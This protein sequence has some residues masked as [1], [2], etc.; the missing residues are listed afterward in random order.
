MEC[1]QMFP[2]KGGFPRAGSGIFTLP[3]G[4]GRETGLQGG[5]T[6]ILNAG[7]RNEH[8]WASSGILIMED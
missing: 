6:G 4:Y 3:E 8:I 5:A 2:V 7:K 1:H